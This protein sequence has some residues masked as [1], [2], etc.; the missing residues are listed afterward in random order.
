MPEDEAMSEQTK[1]LCEECEFFNGTDKIGPIRIIIC[2]ESESIIFQKHIG[3]PTG[4]F[5]EKVKNER[6]SVQQ[7]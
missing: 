2:S 1:S 7:R 5:K 6:R 4:K 3:C